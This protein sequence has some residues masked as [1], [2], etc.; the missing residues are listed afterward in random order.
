MIPV[1]GVVLVTDPPRTLN[2]ENGICRCP[3]G[4]LLDNLT[5]DLQECRQCEANEFIFNSADPSYECQ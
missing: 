5:Y 3:T 2:N 1:V 4:Y